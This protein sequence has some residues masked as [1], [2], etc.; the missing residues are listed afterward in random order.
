MTT[1]AGI[2]PL[3]IDQVCLVVRNME[4]TI[5]QLNLLMNIGPFEIR[6]NDRPDDIVHGRRTRVQAK[7]GFAQ[8]G[9]VEL[10]LIEPGEGENI[11]W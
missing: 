4:K 3:E 5:K 1:K 9:A 6:E 7:L 2:K 10:E 11:Y 8:A